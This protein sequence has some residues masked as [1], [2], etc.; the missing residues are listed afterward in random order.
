MG[1]QIIS[2]CD[3]VVTGMIV[4]LWRPWEVDLP[5][6]AGHQQTLLTWG[7]L[8]RR[9]DSC[10][11]R[12]AGLPSA[13]R[14]QMHYNPFQENRVYGHIIETTALW[15][16]AV[17]LE[18]TARTLTLLYNKRGPRFETQSSRARKRSQKSNIRL[19]AT[20]WTACLKCKDLTPAFV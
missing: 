4:C 8:L 7:A 11:D 3:I 2:I 19:A 10:S 1:K 20:A 15:R 14:I 17:T 12:K 6:L 16:C 13:T 9:L 18:E 5:W